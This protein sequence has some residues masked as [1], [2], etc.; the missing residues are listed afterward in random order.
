[1]PSLSLCHFLDFME[2]LYLTIV[3]ATITKTTTKNIHNKNQGISL[4]LIFPLF[5]QCTLW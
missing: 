3:K 2:N 4:L 1:M 5:Y